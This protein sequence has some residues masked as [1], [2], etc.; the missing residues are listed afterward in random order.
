MTQPVRR[1]LVI[2]ACAFAVA[3]V[4][5]FL[6][7]P[8]LTKY[9][10]PT[11]F[12]EVTSFLILAAL[13][14]NLVGMSSHG[15]VAVRFFK[16]AADQF[17]TAVST[18][19]GMLGVMHVVAFA[20]VGLGH[21]LL[22]RALGLSLSEVL[23]AVVAAL[24]LNLNFVF[25]AIFQSS[26]QPWRYLQ[27]RVLQGS[28]ELGLCLALLFLVAAEASARTNSYTIALAASAL[29]GWAYCAAQGRVSARVEM[30]WVRE[31]LRFGGPLLPHIVAGTA[32][33]YMDRLV[34]TSLLGIE[35]LGIYM[36]A[37]Q[38]GMAM[39]ALIEPLNKALAPWLFHQLNKNDEGIRRMIVKRTFQLFLVLIVAGIVLAE[40]GD[41]L[42]DHFVGAA[43]KDARSLIPW[44]VG[45]FVMQGMYYTQVNY[46]FFTERTG[47][48]SMVTGTTAV[49]GVGISYLLVTNFGM[50]GAGVS[51]FVNNLITFSTVWCVANKVMP[52][53]WWRK[54]NE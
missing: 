38:F 33:T 23:L 30:M 41:L 34:V 42:F 12:G 10:T 37:M 11:Q 6:L 3:G 7:L 48:L 54:S 18:V 9:L 24:F 53:P 8:L 21:P 26:S 43:F 5:P 44:V 25:L 2:Y 51:F 27:S 36:V 19:I 45:G 46:F 22:E 50:M 28:I 49:V 39:I 17:K 14:G 29:M 20:V 15:F 40:A 32:I 47:V 4:T 31:M 1:A 35:S 16:T 52:M 13:L